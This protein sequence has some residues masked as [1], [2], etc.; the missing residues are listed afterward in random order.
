MEQYQKQS[1]TEIK[2]IRQVED[3]ISKDELLKQVEGHYKELTMIQTL[4]NSKLALIAEG[5]K[6][7]VK[8]SEEVKIAEKLLEVQS[9][10]IE[11]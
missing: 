6:L 5:D 7:G 2:V 10:V 1:E 9:E 8:T 3:I 4:I 11:K